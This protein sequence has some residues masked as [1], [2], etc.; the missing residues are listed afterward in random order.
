VILLD[1]HVWVW[2]IHGAPE[3]PKA[4]GEFLERQQPTGIGVSA[5]SAWE[6]AKLVERARLILPCPVDEWMRDALASSG[7]RLIPL[8]PEIAI[9]STRLPGDFHRDPADQIIVAS[10]RVLGVLLVTLDD[11]IRRYP[12]VDTLPGPPDT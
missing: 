8:T 11:K 4:V 2:W 1:T 6:V 9:A 7:V 3:L 12:H 5:I 10:A